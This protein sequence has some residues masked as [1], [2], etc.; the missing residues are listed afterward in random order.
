ML[1]YD[2]VSQILTFPPKALYAWIVA[3]LLAYVLLIPSHFE[4]SGFSF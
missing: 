2:E 1:K 4:N 3:G